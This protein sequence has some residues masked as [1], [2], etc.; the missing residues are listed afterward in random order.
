MCK[1]VPIGFAMYEN[2]RAAELVS[3]AVY[4]CKFNA[5]RSVNTLCRDVGYDRTAVMDTSHQ[6]LHAFLIAFLA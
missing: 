4:V 1:N 6:D 5:A 3:V 2:A